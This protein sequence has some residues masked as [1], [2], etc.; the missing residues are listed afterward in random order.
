LEHPSTRSCVSVT[1]WL[2]C[3]MCHD[4]QDESI[5][6]AVHLQGLPPVQSNLPRQF[7]L[8]LAQVSSLWTIILI[9]RMLPLLILLLTYQLIDLLPLLAHSPNPSGAIILMNNWLRYSADLLTLSTLIRLP[10]LILIQGELKSA[11]LTLSVALSLTS[12]IIFCFNAG[13]ISALIKR[14]ST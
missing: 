5:K 10:H 2:I 1:K 14:N 8:S 7:C 4:I 9:G 11:S 12:L 13:Y 6:E 3:Q